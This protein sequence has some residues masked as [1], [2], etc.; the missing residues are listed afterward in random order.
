MDNFKSQEA[1]DYNYLY[2]VS[3]VSIK[4]RT[5]EDLKKD[6]EIT[7]LEYPSWRN[8]TFEEYC[9]FENG[10]NRDK[11]KMNEEDNSYFLDLQKAKSSVINNFAD[12]NDCGAYNYAVIKKVPM[13]RAYGMIH[14]EE[15][16]LFK[17]NLDTYGYTEVSLNENDETK[18]ITSIISPIN[19]F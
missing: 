14:V 19:M 18:Y 15:I 4:E 6:F 10:W 17:Y 1:K 3:T 13:N 2:I 8:K 16:Y 5:K 11:Y 12:I 7:K 9:E